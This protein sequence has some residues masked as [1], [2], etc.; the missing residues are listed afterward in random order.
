MPGRGFSRSSQRP[1]PVTIDRQMI[2]TGSHL[3]FFDLMIQEIIDR[4]WAFL[5]LVVILALLGVGANLRTRHDR[6]LKRRALADQRKTPRPGPDRRW[7]AR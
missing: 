4:P 6:K 3:A 5:T 7:R 2:F 1:Q